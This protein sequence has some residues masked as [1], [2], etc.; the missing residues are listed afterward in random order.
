MSIAE[1]GAPGCE[2]ES[3]TSRHRQARK[4]T[5][6]VVL[7]LAG[8][9]PCLPFPYLP[10]IL[11]PLR[12]QAR[13]WELQRGALTP[14]PSTCQCVFA[15]VCGSGWERGVVDGDPADCGEAGS[16]LPS[17]PAPAPLPAAVLVAGCAGR[18]GRG[19]SLMGIRRIAARPGRCCPHPRP[20]PQP[21]CR[22]QG[23]RVGLGEGCR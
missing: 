4:Q 20:R 12:T 9:F 23:V 19:V 14:G 11:S 21:R 7:N 22:W 3:I 15:W 5:C 13:A 18:A 17:P 1:S 2:E 16:M 10:A 8:L 6:Q